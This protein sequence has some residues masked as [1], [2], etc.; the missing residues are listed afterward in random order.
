MRILI[1]DDDERSRN[2]LEKILTEFSSVPLQFKHAENGKRAIEIVQHWQ[3]ARVFMDIR[4]PELDG[5]AATPQILKAHPLT[6]IIIVSQLDQREYRRQARLQGAVGFV[7][8]QNLFDA[9]YWVNTGEVERTDR[10]D[11]SQEGE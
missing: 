7:S 4:M 6:R 8:K 11:S 3:P 5:L 10:S 2:L 1:A 9:L